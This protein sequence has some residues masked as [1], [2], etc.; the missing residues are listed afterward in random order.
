LKLEDKEDF[1]RNDPSKGG[2]DTYL[3]MVKKE[4][5]KDDEGAAIIDPG[6]DI[7]EKFEEIDSLTNNARRLNNT[8]NAPIRPT[9]PRDGS[10]DNRKK[11]PKSNK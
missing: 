9:T 10:S 3:E 5:F 8:M 1:L 2:L 11:G 4:A 7:K 6:Y